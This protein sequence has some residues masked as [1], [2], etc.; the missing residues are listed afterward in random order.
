MRRSHLYLKWLASKVSRPVHIHQQQYLICWKWCQ[1]TYGNLISAI[2]WNKSF[3]SCGSV[4]TTVWMYHV[5][6]N[7][8]H[9]EK[10]RWELYMNA[11]C[12]FEQKLEATPHK[13]A[14]VWPP[15]S[16]PIQVRWTKNVEHCW[17]SKD[18]LISNVLICIHFQTNTLG[19]GMDHILS[20]LSFYKDG[21]GIK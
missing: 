11:M 10:A 6:T 12:C 3:P 4:N 5:D 9:W 7:K 21:F 17:R 18:K 2:K 1:H 14:A 19:K 8:M 16:K 15:T 13:K 20:L